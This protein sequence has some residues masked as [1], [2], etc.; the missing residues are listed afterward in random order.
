MTISAEELKQ[1]LSVLLQEAEWFK[2]LVYDAIENSDHL[3][4]EVRQIAKD[5]AEDWHNGNFS[6]KDYSDAIE[7][8]VDDKIEDI[9]FAR[10]VCGALEDDAD[11][12]AEV[13]KITEHT[14]SEHVTIRDLQDDRDDLD[15]RVSEIETVVKRLPPMPVLTPEVQS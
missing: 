1:N 8:I 13:E 9:D 12:I 3:S 10:K 2:T 5:A 11:V 14:V 15:G 7:E 6:I 4:K